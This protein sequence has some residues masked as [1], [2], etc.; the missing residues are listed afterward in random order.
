MGS[1]VDCYQV[2]GRSQ[3][4]EN[5]NMSVNVCPVMN[6]K[7]NQTMKIKTETKNMKTIKS[8][9]FYLIALNYH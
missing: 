3:M 4:C 6:E 9:H 7:I 5:E 8:N 2:K 1:A